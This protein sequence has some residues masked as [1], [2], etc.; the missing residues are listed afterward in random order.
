M[1]TLSKKVDRTCPILFKNKE[2]CCG[3]A[4]CVVICPTSAIL[5]KADEEGF[6]YPLIDNDTCI[7]CYQ[8]LKVCPLKIK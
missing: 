5:M 6:N 1:Q 7:R 4:A 8:C 3:C 2:D